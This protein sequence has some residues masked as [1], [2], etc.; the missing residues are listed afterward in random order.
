MQLLLIIIATEFAISMGF[1]NESLSTNK[2]RLATIN[3][4]MINVCLFVCFQRTMENLA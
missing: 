4:A 1:K 3:D 2:S